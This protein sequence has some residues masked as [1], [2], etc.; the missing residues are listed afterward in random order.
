M[1]SNFPGLLTKNMQ[2]L[3]TPLK[4][5]EF[6]TVDMFYEARW[7][8]SPSWAPF[9][10]P[11]SFQP[12]SISF[13]TCSLWAFVL[14]CSSILLVKYAV[15]RNVY[16]HSTSVC[17]IAIHTEVSIQSVLPRAIVC[18]CIVS[19]PVSSMVQTHSLTKFCDIFS[20]LLKKKKKESQNHFIWGTFPFRIRSACK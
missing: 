8:V 13:F 18:P 10:E 20:R 16:T 2:T 11:Q 3:P 15:L 17:L 6:L 5:R 1:L 19:T 12:I 4:S 14:P 9:W 7:I